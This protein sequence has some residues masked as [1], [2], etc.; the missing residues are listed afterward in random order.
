MV[1][2]TFWKDTFSNWL[3]KEN[4]DEKGLK[5]LWGLQ[6]GRL[7]SG[8]GVAGKCRILQRWA[9]FQG[10]VMT[11]PWTRWTWEDNEDIQVEISLESWCSKKQGS[12]CT[13]KSK[14]Q[15]YYW[16]TE[17]SMPSPKEK[18]DGRMQRL[19]TTREMHLVKSKGYKEDLLTERKQRSVIQEKEPHLRVKLICSEEYFIQ[20]YL[21]FF[22]LPN[23]LYCLVM[24][25]NLL[26]PLKL[27]FHNH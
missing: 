12:R 13:L 5:N 3:A 11:P 7:A 26:L 6:P 20:K 24:Q 1:K 18:V 14:D 27:R 9:D 16:E 10:I 22:F 2:Q 21:F 17:D 8:Y 25:L 19:R 15:R 4:T 23:Y